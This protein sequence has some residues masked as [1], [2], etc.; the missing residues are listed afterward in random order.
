MSVERTIIGGIACYIFACLFV[1]ATIVRA[2]SWLIELVSPMLGWLYRIGTTF[3]VM[4]IG[5]AIL[6]RAP[7]IFKLVGLALLIMGA[8]W[9]WIAWT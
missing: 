6:E 4:F 5:L 3:G 9:S 8:Y 2:V 1:I 7:H